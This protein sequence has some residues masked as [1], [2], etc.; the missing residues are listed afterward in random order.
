MQTFE[1]TLTIQKPA[2]EVF[3]FLADFENIPMWNYA[4]EE[5][6]K[7]SAGPAG[8]G[9][10]YR[11]T[12]S[13]PSTSIEDFEV[14]VF[15]PASRLAI[16]GQIGPFQA[17]ISYVLEAAGGATKLVNN[18]EL[19]PAQAKLRLLAPLATPKI[20]AAVA[21]NLAKLKLILEGGRPA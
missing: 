21:Q 11:Q 13:I 6:S 5:T 9:T 3:A 8:V 20:K 16:H 2:E 4:I 19:D 10:R 1:N 15:E 17:T 12:R 18:V 7:A 14:T